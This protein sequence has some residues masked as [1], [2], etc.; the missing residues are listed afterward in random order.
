MPPSEFWE[1]RDTTRLCVWAKQQLS[2]TGINDLANLFKY[3]EKS[4]S[5]LSSNANYSKNVVSH[6]PI[7]FPDKLVIPLTTLNKFS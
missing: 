6:I 4:I 3:I 1:V 2:I 7:N 5:S